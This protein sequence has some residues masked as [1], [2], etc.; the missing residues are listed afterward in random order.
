MPKIQVNRVANANVY[1]D[2]ANLLGR[3]NSVTPPA[4]KQMMEEHHGLGMVGK[5]KVPTGGL[6]LDDASFEWAS[7]YSD[8]IRKAA[9][10]QTAVQLQVRASIDEYTGAGLTGQTPLV[11]LMNGIFH[12]LPFGK[13][14]QHKPITQESKFTAYY[15]KVVADGDALVEV[16]LFNNIYKVADDDL[17]SR[18]RS[19]IGG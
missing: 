18:F 2:G 16:D 19:I 15:L 4:I 7:F 12:E 5:L 10:A 17:L 11:I 14:E 3:A 1:I 6:E 13:F 8:V 9:N